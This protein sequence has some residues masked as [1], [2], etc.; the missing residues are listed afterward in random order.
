MSQTTLHPRSSGVPALWE[1]TLDVFEA[2]QQLILDR[3]ELVRAEISEDLS[4]LALG[5]AFVVGAGVLALLGYVTFL[6]AIIVLLAKALST[7]AAL[8]IGGGFHLLIGVLL[9]A[10]GV[11]SLKRMRLATP[12]EAT[13]H[14]VEHHA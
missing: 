3:I 11:S 2:G 12:R 8:A 14:E 4:R 13:D 7:E 10:V 5:L 6:A 1:A 9:A